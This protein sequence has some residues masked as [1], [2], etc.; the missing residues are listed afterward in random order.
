MPLGEPKNA[1]A[2][3]NQ[4]FFV[5]EFRGMQDESESEHWARHFLTRDRS[6][7]NLRGYPEAIQV[8]AREEL[9][10]FELDYLLKKFFFLGDS[11]WATAVSIKAPVE[12]LKDRMNVFRKYIRRKS[13]KNPRTARYFR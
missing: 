12:D 3:T 11:S 4:K 13:S 1:L 10:A 2:K 5:E 8:H 9:D 6:K 7:I